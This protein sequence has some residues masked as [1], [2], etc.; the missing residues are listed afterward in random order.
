MSPSTG[1]ERV[2][3]HASKMFATNTESQEE[4]V[5]LTAVKENL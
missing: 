2:T 4:R 5:P 1:A 3:T